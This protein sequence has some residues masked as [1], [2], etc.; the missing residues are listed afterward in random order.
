MARELTVEDLDD[1]DSF[2]RLHLEHI[3]NPP[4]NFE[5]YKKLLQN[6]I[7]NGSRYILGVYGP[8]DKAMGLLN[9]NPETN[10]VSLIFAKSQFEVEKELFDLLLNRF[11]ESYPALTFESGY[12]TPWIS[13]ELS[14]YAIQCGFAK[15]DRLYMR[16]Q[17]TDFLIPPDFPTSTKLI[18]FTDTMIEEI[19]ELVF[20]SVDGSIDQDLFPYVYGTYETTLRFHQQLSAGEFGNHKPSYSWVMKENDESIGVCFMTVDNVDSGGIMHIAIAPEH[21]QKGLGRV[22]LV[23]SIHNLFKIETELKS[24]YLAVTVSNPATALYESVGFKK[25][26]ESSAYVLKKD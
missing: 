11:A 5:G 13:S 21:R 6:H 10:R 9:H 17:W 12:P 16:L 14:D 3:G 7:V 1:F 26:N 25:V 23:H 2:L 4:T 20:R 22:L 18:P 24:I 15:H 19:T 8:D